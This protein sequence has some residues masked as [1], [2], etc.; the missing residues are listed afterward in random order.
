MGIPEKVEVKCSA[1]GKVILFGEHAVVYGTTAVAASLSDLRIFVQVKLVSLSSNSSSSPSD[2]LVKF[3]DIKDDQGEI[4][5]CRLPF[6]KLQNFR[7]LTKVPVFNTS[8]PTTEMLL[9]L[10]EEFQDYNSQSNQC[11]M[12][13]SYLSANLLSGVLEMFI[14]SNTMLEIDIYSENLP[15]GAG[16]GSSLSSSLALSSPW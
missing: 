1:P 9:R 12:A 6:T 8:R 14:D 10:R 7:I 11:I 13:L 15:F 16:L 5:K 3:H 2:I 4:I